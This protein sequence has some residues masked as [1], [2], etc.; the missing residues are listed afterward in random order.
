MPESVAKTQKIVEE[1]NGGLIESLGDLIV[2]LWDV[3]VSLAVLVAPWWPLIAWVA[4][5]LFAVNWVKFRAVLLEGGWIG[6][7]LLGLLMV[8]VWGTIAPPAE[9]THSI[10]GLTLSNYVGKTVYVT[11]LFS[12]MFLCGSVQLAGSWPACCQFADDDQPEEESHSTH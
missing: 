11:T 5:W 8:L 7:V 4:F 6:L 1:A 10:F 9:G 12:I 3:F 2:A